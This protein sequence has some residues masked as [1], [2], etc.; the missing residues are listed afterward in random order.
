MAVKPKVN[1]SAKHAISSVTVKYFDIGCLLPSGRKKT[2]R[3][4]SQF[5]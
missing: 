1:G 5:M 4:R 3:L 2:K